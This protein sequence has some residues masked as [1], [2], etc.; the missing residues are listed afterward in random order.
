MTF[1]VGDYPLPKGLTVVQ[2]RVLL[3]LCTDTLQPI[4]EMLLVQAGCNQCVSILLVAGLS[5]TR[6]NALSTTCVHPP[7][8]SPLRLPL[9]LHVRLGE[10]SHVFFASSCWLQRYWRPT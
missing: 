3:L 5:V 2:R 1:C 9:P 8:L 4:S 7:P 10:T 6:T